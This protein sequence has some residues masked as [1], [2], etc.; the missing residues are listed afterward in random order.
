MT[1]RFAPRTDTVITTPLGQGNK[2]LTITRLPWADFSARFAGR[3]QP[4]GAAIFVAPDHPDYPPEWLTRHYGVLCLGWPGV[5]EQT[6]QPGQAIRCRYRV[7]I[8][9][10]APTVEQVKQTYRAYED[11]FAKK[12]AAQ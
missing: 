9:R 2:D 6:F 4:S 8:H 12:P 1:L 10:G 3:A 11:S 5:K 7:W